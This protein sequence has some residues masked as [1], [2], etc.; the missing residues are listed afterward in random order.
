MS[1]TTTALATIENI[2]AVDFFKPGAS[3]SI[4]DNL[5][6]EARAIASSLDVSK[7]ADRDAMRSLAAKLGKTKTKLDAAG[8]D[9]V[10]GEKA[11]LKLIDTERGVVWD[12][13]EALQ[14][15]VRQ[16]L[17]DWENAE[18]DRVARHEAELAELISAGEF[19][20]QNWQALPVETM[21]D[22]LAEIQNSNYDWEEFI[23]RAKSAVVT[24]IFQIKDAIA[25]REKADADA[26][27]LAKL[28]EEQAKREQQER[29]AKIAAEAKAAAEAEARAREE[30]AAKAAQEEKERVER[31]RF[32]AEAR[33]KAAEVRREAE[34][35][36]AKQ[37]AE[38]AEKRH[39]EAVRLAEEKAKADQAAAVEAERQRQI[40]DKAAEDAEKAKREANT[41]HLAKINREVRDALMRACTLLDVDIFTEAVAQELTAAIAKGLIPHTKINY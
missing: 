24:S 20:L 9:L 6:E 18:K 5:K 33:A 37:E 38:D 26:A 25:K 3:K 27:E 2:T 14:K 1:T 32:E 31:E 41:K 13:L 23:G 29:E 15:E 7:N 22:R 40:D 30:R 35:A 8:K 12:D 10:A 16:P 39:A 21:K 11:R 4:L 34:A 19:T 17:T 28:R 36:K